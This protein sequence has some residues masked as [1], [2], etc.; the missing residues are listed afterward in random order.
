MTDQ[1]CFRPRHLW[2]LVT[3]AP[4]QSEKPR[5]T[6]NARHPNE[7]W[8]DKRAANDVSRALVPRGP[9]PLLLCTDRGSL[10]IFPAQLSSEGVSRAARGSTRCRAPS[11]SL[12][13]GRADQIQRGQRDGGKPVRRGGNRRS[14]R[15]LLSPR[16]TITGAREDTQKSEPS[17]V[18][19]G[20][21]RRGSRWGKRPSS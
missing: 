5:A 14:P 6:G 17:C 18:A 13:D 15:E 1:C 21:L 4:G 2:S 3:A 12:R 8:L 7:R 19:G 16:R 9:G 20:S 10:N 11:V